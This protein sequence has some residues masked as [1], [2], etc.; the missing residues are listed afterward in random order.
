[1]FHLIVWKEGEQYVG[2]VLEN[3]I[4]SFWTTEQIAYDNTIE[5]LQLYLEDT[6]P[7]EPQITS[8]KLYSL[9]LCHA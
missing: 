5:A 8:P 3:S 6:H 9:D 4:S 2:K 7:E 1:M